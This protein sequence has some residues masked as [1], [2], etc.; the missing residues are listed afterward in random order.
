MQSLGNGL[1]RSS[2]LR[3]GAMGGG[4]LIASA[5]GLGA[6][7]PSAFADAPPAGDLAYLRL[8]IAAEPSSSV[9]P[10]L[11]PPLMPPPASHM[12]KP[13]AL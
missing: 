2:F 6:L 5:S 3:R 7:A 4:A 10:T 9:S 11:T 12:V 8:L 13:N 1:S